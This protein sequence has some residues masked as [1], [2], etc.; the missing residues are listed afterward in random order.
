[1]IQWV[2]ELER[3]LD[4]PGTMGYNKLRRLK[5]EKFQGN[6][7]I[8]FNKGKIVSINPYETIDMD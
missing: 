4:R 1:M 8:N 3:K 2:R 7:R 5:E 6:I